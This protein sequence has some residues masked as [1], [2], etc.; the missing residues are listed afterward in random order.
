MIL[1]S[2]SLDNRKRAFVLGTER[3]TLSYPYAKCDPP[4]TPEDR[5]VEYWIDDEL[6]REGLTYRLSSGRDGCVLVDMALDYNREPSYMRDLLL[7]ELTVQ[8]LRSL[9]ASNLAK[10]EVIRRLGTSPAQLYRLLDPTDYGKSVD[11]MLELLSVL[12][13]D[14]ELTVRQ[15][16]A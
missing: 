4:P 7:H 2:V 10:R 12:G 16:T 3:G 11:K 8:A 15:R 1:Q 13:C 9:E 5:I 14:V 6:A